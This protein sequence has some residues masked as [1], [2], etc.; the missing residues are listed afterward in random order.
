MST[1][2]K[3]GLDCHCP[4]KMLQTSLS[5][6][7]GGSFL[8]AVTY[9][10]TSGLPSA[11]FLGGG[12]GA[13]AGSRKGGRGGREGR[14]KR[15]VLF[16]SLVRTSCRFSTWPGSSCSL[17]GIFFYREAEVNSSSSTMLLSVTSASNFM[18]EV[19]PYIL[20]WCLTFL[21]HSLWEVGTFMIAFRRPAHT[22]EL[23]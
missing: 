22:K 3:Q 16:F 21:S 4:Q 13:E 5:N 8:G 18:H 23:F 11:W 20:L 15:G 10:G 12:G 2:L 7:V 19:R 6:G 1:G 14:G 9:A 17:L